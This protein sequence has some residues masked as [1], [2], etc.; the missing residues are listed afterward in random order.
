MIRTAVAPLRTA[1]LNAAAATMTAAAL[2][3]AGMVM[4]ATGALGCTVDAPVR[5]ATPDGPAWRA[6][7]AGLAR[8]GVAVDAAN[9]HIVALDNAVEDRMSRARALRPLNDLLKAYPGQV[10]DLR[11]IKDDWRVVGIIS[12]V[13]SWHLM[14]RRDILADVGIPA[15]TSYGEM[16]RVAA[17]LH[18]IKAADTP[19]ALALE[20]GDDLAQTFIDVYL[21]MGGTLFLEGFDASIYN[22]RGVATLEMFQ[23][24]AGYAPADYMETDAADVE[25]K[26]LNGDIVMAVLPSDRAAHVAQAMGGKI[27]MA[28]APISGWRPAATVQWIGLGVSADAT[29]A[30]AA[31]AL[32]AIIG[33]VDA[34]MAA[35]NPDAAN[36]FIDG[37]EPAM[38]SAA[39]VVTA[40]EGA[41]TYPGGP[42]MQ[43]LREAIAVGIEPYLRGEVDPSGA[44]LDIELEYK[45]AAQEQGLIN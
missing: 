20:A 10:A 21:G 42:E 16:L 6:I 34:S 31:N 12:A 4:T 44:L 7:D 24:L 45:R 43:L 28:E 23:M 2:S 36:W 29:D 39:A 15:P 22:P 25:A 5:A 32:K 33:G 8:C 3:A 27:A 38:P 17:Q 19:V 37:Y 13:E 41:L 26:L 35:A 1:A 40:R 14:Y 9:P 18:A 30:E 11:L